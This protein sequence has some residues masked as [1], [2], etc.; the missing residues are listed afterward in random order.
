VTHR[1]VRVSVGA[2]EIAALQGRV[3]ALEAENEAQTAVIAGLQA[4]VDARQTRLAPL[5]GGTLASPDG[6]YVITVANDGIAIVGPGVGIGLNT[7]NPAATPTVE[8]AATDV[9]VIAARNTGIA[10]GV[11]TS[12]SSDANTSI[13]SGVATNVSSAAATSLQGSPVRL[14]GGCAGV[15]RVG[16]FVVQV[17]PLL[18]IDTGSTT[19]LGC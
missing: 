13:A 9:I 8:V 18:Q 11:A 17:G 19:V 4:Q 1:L 14:N 12:I 7:N 16:D 10:S 6:R 5:L 15:A 2:A 3:A